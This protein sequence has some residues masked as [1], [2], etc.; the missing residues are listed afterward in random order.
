MTGSMPRSQ[1]RVPFEGSQAWAFPDAKDQARARVSVEAGRLRTSWA[2]TRA[3]L[4]IEDPMPRDEDDLSFCRALADGV[5]L[6]VAER[7][8]AR[9][10]K[11]IAD[12]CERLAAERHIPMSELQAA[13]EALLLEWDER[14]SEKQESSPTGAMADKHSTK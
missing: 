4:R 5:I 7:D 3:L 1:R 13:V 9:V 11:A 2:H 14:L 8:P 6:S 10:A 12:V